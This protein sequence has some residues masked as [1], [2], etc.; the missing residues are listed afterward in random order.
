MNIHLA[1]DLEQFVQAKVKWG[2]FTSSD[3]AISGAMRLF[4][5]RE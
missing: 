3:Q 4:E 5:Q 1:E 2:R